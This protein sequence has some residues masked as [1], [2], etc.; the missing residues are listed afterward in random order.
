MGW[1]IAVA[2]C[3]VCGRRFAFDVDRVQAVLMDRETMLTPDLG[4]DPDR[5]QREPICPAC[6][7]LANVIRRQAG[8]ELLD[9][10]D[11][12]QQGRQ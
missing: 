4:G 2:P 10:T 12:A 9:E 5:A 1:M 6:C 3:I 8:L 7:K 11:T